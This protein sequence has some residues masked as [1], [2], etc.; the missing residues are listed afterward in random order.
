MQHG[1]VQCNHATFVSMYILL[2][3]ELKSSDTM[4]QVYIYVHLGEVNSLYLSLPWKLSISQMHSKHPNTHEFDSNKS[5]CP[6]RHILDFFSFDRIKLQ[7]W[8]EIMW[9]LQCRRWMLTEKWWASILARSNLYLYVIIGNHQQM[10]E[11]LGNQKIPIYEKHM[12]SEDWW[13]AI[14][15]YIL[16]YLQISIIFFY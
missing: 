9:P 13:T 3:R 7:S 1:S 11:V 8:G 5:Y 14:T 4:Y 16:C 10:K 12:E 15:V 6:G 2:C